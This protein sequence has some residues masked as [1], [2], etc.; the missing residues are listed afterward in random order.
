MYLIV[1]NFTWL[2]SASTIVEMIHALVAK[3]FRPVCG[4]ESNLFAI[5]QVIATFSIFSSPVAMT[6][7]NAYNPGNSQDTSIILT[8]VK[9]CSKYMRSSYVQ[10]LETIMPE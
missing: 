3:N 2:S 10:L 7:F 5:F 6:R 8:V 1:E 4:T 9:I